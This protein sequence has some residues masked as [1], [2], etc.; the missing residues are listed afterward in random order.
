MEKAKRNQH[1]HLVD[2]NYQKLHE[3]FYK[4]D[5]EGIFDDSLLRNNY[6][7]LIK[8]RNRY[9]SGLNHK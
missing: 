1:L 3:Y 6:S 2:I 5:E 7:D 4:I 9:H 8:D